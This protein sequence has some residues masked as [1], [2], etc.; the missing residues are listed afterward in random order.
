MERPPLLERLFFS[1]VILCGLVY[2]LARWHPHLVD[3]AFI[4]FRYARNVVEGNGFVYNAGERVLGT[5]T[6]L[7]TLLLVALGWLGA[8]I[9]TC[10]FLIGF[11]AG[12]ACLVMIVLLGHEAGSERAGWCAA[13]AV[14][15]QFWWVAMLYS[16]METTLFT[17]LHLL[18]FHATLTQRWQWTGWLMGLVCLTR[19]DGVIICVVI[20]AALWLMAGRRRALMEGGKAAL[21]FLPWLIFA[22]A[23]FG[24]VVPLS[25]KAKI[26]M[27]APTW[28]ATWFH[29]S[30]WLQY[31]SLWWAWLA[32][33]TAGGVLLARAERRWIVP[34]VWAALFLA[35]F[36]LRRA[37][38]WSFGWY[39]V[40]LVPL[41]TLLALIGVERAVAVLPRVSK[42]RA[43]V[44]YPVWAVL[45]LLQAL[46]LVQLEPSLG[47]RAMNREEA[48]RLTAEALR[49]RMAPGESVLLGEIGAM[50]WYLPDMRIIDGAGLVSPAVFEVLRA[51]FVSMRAEGIDSLTA[52]PAAT[53]EI[54]RRERPDFISTRD[55]YMNMKILRDDPEF[56][57]DYGEVTDP[58]LNIFD[59]V[60]Y[61]RKDRT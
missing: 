34:T 26:T 11:A 45:I 20:F 48:Y 16:G 31:H 27:S 39:L 54:L 33:A 24:S 43:E 1:A 13:V 28:A 56:Q 60:C 18:L 21:L 41:V 14:T 30:G 2:T 42:Y 10:G 52:R 29:F 38:V 40:P 8:P 23:Y 25:A 59:Q 61:K 32:A 35:V 46:K 50:G 55:W 49:E 58:R 22:A 53:L 15:W 6:P 9:P 51:D 47:A 19:Y 57:R 17:L 5:S 7:M 4:T 12:L 3:D 36:I 44:V 37:A